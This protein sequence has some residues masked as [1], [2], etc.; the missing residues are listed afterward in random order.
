MKL[1]IT[2]KSDL[3][4]RALCALGSQQERVKGSDLAEHIETTTGFLPQVL[5]P[6]VRQK[7]IRSSP[8]P[9]GGY[10]LETSLD[11]IS[12]LEVIEAVE[13]PLEQDVC[14]L[15]GGICDEADHCV[16]HEAWLKAR[17]E[18]YRELAATPISQTTRRQE[19]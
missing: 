9:T 18:L 13:G 6:L 19:C 4:V 2:R 10:V 7:W 3:A 8:G 17:G 14:V 15:D 5:A 12:L 11:D 16:I 1:E